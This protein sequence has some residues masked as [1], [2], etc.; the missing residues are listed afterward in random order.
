MQQ[1]TDN[2]DSFCAAAVPRIQQLLRG[3][4]NQYFALGLDAEYSVPMGGPN[5]GIYAFRQHNPLKGLVF[6]DAG[7]TY[8][9]LLVGQSGTGD[10]Q[11]PLIADTRALL[12]H[13]GVLLSG[14]VGRV[15]NAVSNGFSAPETQPRKQL[16]LNRPDAFQLERLDEDDHCIDDSKLTAATFLPWDMKICASMV[17]KGA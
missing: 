17:Q 12:W 16:Y 4:Q 1:P 11:R 8:R 2:Q 15:L 3:N 10:L 6:K 14:A 9:K 13:H 5:V 7:N